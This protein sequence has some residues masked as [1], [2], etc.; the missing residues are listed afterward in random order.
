MNVRAATS[1]VAVACT[2]VI[3][4]CTTDVAA[5]PLILLTNAWREVGNENRVFFITDDTGGEP[6]K[7]GTFG[8]SEV[9]DDEYELDG[10]WNG[11]RIR[12]TVYRN[13]VV[14]WRATVRRSEPDTLVF[15]RS[16][17][18]GVDSLVVFR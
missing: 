7:S 6:R 2:A 18:G 10:D 11:G 1:Y 14:T 15:T 5:G 13:P 12:M 8:G 3:V 16:V 4:A 9:D 17:S